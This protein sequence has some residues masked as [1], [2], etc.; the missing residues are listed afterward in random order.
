MYLQ[1]VYV[2]LYGAISHAPYVFLRGT[3]KGRCV[4]VCV[5]DVSDS[6]STRG[7]EA[8]KSTDLSDWSLMSVK[9]ERRTRVP[10]WRA[11]SWMDKGQTQSDERVSSL[12]TQ[13]GSHE[14]WRWVIKRSVCLMPA[15]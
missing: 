15:S 8:K 13:A 11:R 5:L 1:C 14:Q 2:C 9:Y 12:F 10:Q 6:V 3:V 4:C 7:R